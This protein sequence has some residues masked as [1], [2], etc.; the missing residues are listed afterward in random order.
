MW[1]NPS[2][3]LA[4]QVYRS[5]AGH[6]AKRAAGASPVNHH[7]K[8]Y[9]GLTSSN[10]AASAVFVISKVITVQNFSAKTSQVRR[11]DFWAG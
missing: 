4:G 3:R 6:A 11:S 2:T 10:Y 9:T 1:P 5:D 7:P 8:V